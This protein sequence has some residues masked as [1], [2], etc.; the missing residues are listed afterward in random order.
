MLKYVVKIWHI[1]SVLLSTSVNGINFIKP[2]WLV[3]YILFFIS[4]LNMDV[5]LSTR[6]NT[7]ALWFTQLIGTDIDWSDSDKVSISIS[8]YS[9]KITKWNLQTSKNYQQPESS[10]GIFQL[11]LLLFHKMNSLNYRWHL[12]DLEIES[13]LVTSTSADKEF[14]TIS[15]NGCGWINNWKWLW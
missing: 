10:I 14:V 2:F 4:V 7:F 3:W 13:Y 8:F 15:A 9:R 12:F 6:T 11:I 5:Y 1:T